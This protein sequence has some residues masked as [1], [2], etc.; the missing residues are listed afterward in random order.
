MAFQYIDEPLLN[1][2]MNLIKCDYIKYCDNMEC[3][4]IHN[5]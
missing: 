1:E 5:T 3:T 4:G 2:S